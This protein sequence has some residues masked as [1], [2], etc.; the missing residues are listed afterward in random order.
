M[1]RDQS[2]TDAVAAYLGTVADHLGGIPPDEREEILRNVEAHVYDALES[3]AGA[4]ATAEDLQAVLAEM[5]PPA[6]Y[7][8][9]RPLPPVPVMSAAPG[10]RRSL[11]GWALAM[12]VGGIIL[13]ILVMVAVSF[14]KSPGDD[15][16]IVLSG[17]L[18][19][20][21]QLTAL[22]LAIASWR[23]RMAKVVV[24]II[25][26]MLL[27]MLAA[28]MQWWRATEAYL[29]PANPFATIEMSGGWSE[30]LRR[31]EIPS[32]EASAPKTSAAAQ[33]SR[34]EFLVE[35]GESSLLL[36]WPRI[37]IR[38]R[39]ELA[40][41]SFPL[42]D[43]MGRFVIDGKEKTYR[44]FGPFSYSE[45]DSAPGLD[46][47]GAKVRFPDEALRTRL[48][49]ACRAAKEIWLAPRS[50]DDLPES[51]EI[52]PDLERL[53]AELAEDE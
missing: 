26:L 35:G 34:V 41:Q 38:G 5:D 32:I 7:A 24:I 8:E 12:M 51:L 31:Q 33:P 40:S 13:P 4:A 25:G 20:V 11:A 19:A 28:A 18:A 27:A 45:L 2:I 10:E 3:R 6:S 23:Q 22:G 1:T 52:H 43:L 46:E 36:F 17:F 14:A 47:V 44:I 39:R 42:V 50:L 21:M 37:S 9:G 15:A 16:I 29:E 53:L 30:V 48:A 49:N